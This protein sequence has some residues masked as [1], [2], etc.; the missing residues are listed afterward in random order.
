MASGEVAPPPPASASL[1]TRHPAL[2]PSEIGAP[3]HPISLMRV[4]GDAAL[5]RGSRRAWRPGGCDMSGGSREEVGG[6]F[7]LRRW[8]ISFFKQPE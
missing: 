5:E 8:S 2:N 7:S 4:T 6:R 3:P 1:A